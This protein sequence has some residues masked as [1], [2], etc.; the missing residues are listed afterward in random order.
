MESHDRKPFV[1]LFE[2]LGVDPKKCS[3]ADVEVAF[4]TKLRES[5]ESGTHV[6]R[7]VINA[8]R[9]L[10]TARGRQTYL[11]FLEA[12]E[13]GIPIEVP[14]D[15]ILEYQAFLIL[16][17]FRAWK[18]PRRANWFH[19]RRPDQDPPEFVTAATAPV[20]SLGAVL[21]GLWRFVTFRP[22]IGAGVEKQFALVFV[23]ALVIGLVAYGVDWGSHRFTAWQQAR[24]RD[25]VEANLADADRSADE[26]QQSADR[27]A[28]SFRSATGVTLGASERSRELDLLIRRHA[29]VADALAEIENSRVAAG[30]L[31]NLRTSI[32]GVRERVNR[33]VY[34]ESDDEDLRQMIE[35]CQSQVHANKGLA[36]ELDH[37]D[38]M[39]RAH[40][41][42]VSLDATER[43]FR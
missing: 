27:F 3:D 19:I 13:R 41:L 28:S 8:Y 17:G 34:R 42:N 18:D 36:R 10:R 9:I 35:Q 4:Q 23:Y 14:P 24:L 37:I 11:V 32:R 30:E 26:L 6:S 2:R 39:I 1:C 31:A 12:S 5:D 33:M 40:R 29:S 15:E 43:R 7:D 22:F 21:I 16:A 25:S 20:P 38:T